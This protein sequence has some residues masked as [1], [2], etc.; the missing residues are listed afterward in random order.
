MR[1]RRVALDDEQV[2]PPPKPWADRGIDLAD[3]RVR[4]FLAR[5][6]EPVGR[7]AAEPELARVKPGMLAGQDEPRRMAVRGQR[8]RDG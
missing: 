8:L 7:Q 4:V 1:A 5:A 6:V 3:V 2:R